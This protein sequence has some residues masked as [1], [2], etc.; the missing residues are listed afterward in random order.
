VFCLP[1]R[2]VARESRKAFDF[3]IDENRFTTEAENLNAIGM[4]YYFYCLVC[5]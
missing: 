1:D 4:M 2:V 3:L 5:V